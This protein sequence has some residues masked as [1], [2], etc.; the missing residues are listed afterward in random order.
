MK[1]TVLFI[2]I[3]LIGMSSVFYAQEP[4]REDRRPPVEKIAQLEK[5]KL[6]E[7]LDLKEDV[8]V[9][10]FV[11]RKDYREKQRS[12]FDQ[13]DELIRKIEQKLKDGANQSDKEYKD[14]LDEIFSLD[15]KILQQKE[16]F[17]SS[18]N[19]LLTPQQILKLA[20][21]DNR[22]MREIRKLLMEGRK[23]H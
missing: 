12:L 16:K 15:Q 9:R 2:C 14:Q 6:I 10:F 7:I 5:A 20:V 23:K 17:F 1:K 11:R 19:D 18:L 13:R 4:M 3:L 8:A 21:F 22:F